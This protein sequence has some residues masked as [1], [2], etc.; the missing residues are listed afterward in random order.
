MR[1]PANRQSTQATAVLALLCLWLGGTL[2]AAEV[3][4]KD[5][6]HLRRPVAAAWLDLGKLLAV[7]N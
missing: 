2:W 6:P 4:L 7:A 3:P 5:Q 1:L